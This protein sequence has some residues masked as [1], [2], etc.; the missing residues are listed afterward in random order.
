MNNHKNLL[1]I[2]LF[3][4]CVSYN[5]I[6]AMKRLPEISPHLL[7]AVEEARES[8]KNVDSW[9]ED[10]TEVINKKVKFEAALAQVEVPKRI[11]PVRI[12]LLDIK[13]MPC[14]GKYHCDVCDIWFRTDCNRNRHYKSLKH[15]A[16]IIL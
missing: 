7:Q 16:N 14:N 4:L 6:Q 11:P 5:M 9:H 1:I 12:K 3:S 10:V 2:V 8:Y 13:S 15:Q